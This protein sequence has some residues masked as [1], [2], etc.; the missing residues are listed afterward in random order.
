MKR[1]IFSP[2]FLLFNSSL[3]SYPF[4]AVYPWRVAL[5]DSSVRFGQRVRFHHF[6]YPFQCLCLDSTCHGE[7]HATTPISKPRKVELFDS[8]QIQRRYLMSSILGRRIS[9][10]VS[11]ALPL[12]RKRFAS[13]SFYMSCT[14][15]LRIHTNV[16]AKQ[17]RLFEGDCKAIWKSS[18]DRPSK[19]AGLNGLAKWG[20]M[21][22]S[23]VCLLI[24]LQT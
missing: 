13:F 22:C 1:Q 12:K 20:R 19:A 23:L 6:D 21:R 18:T 17:E 2:S 16:L 4:S 5:P 11:P 3:L 9:C 10:R 8:S 14:N 24:V 7:I 15:S